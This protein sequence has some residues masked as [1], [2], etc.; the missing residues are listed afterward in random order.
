[1]NLIQLLTNENP[2]LVRIISIIFIVVQVNMFHRVF[3]KV[4]NI[5]TTRKKQLIF[6]AISSIFPILALWMPNSLLSDSLILLSFFLLLRHLFEQNIKN[7]LLAI[8]ITYFCVTLAESIVY[9]ICIFLLKLNSEEISNI[10]LYQFLIQLSGCIIFFFMPSVINW[11]KINI[12]KIYKNSK[13]HSKL[14]LASIFISGLITMILVTYLFSTTMGIIPI[15]LMLAIIASLLLYFSLTIYALARTDTLDKTKEDLANAQLYNQTLTILHDNI[16]GFKHDFNNIV[17]AIGGY[18]ALNDMDGLKSYYQRLL[19]ECKLTNNLN[20]LNPET[21]NN[22]SIYSLLTNKYFTATEKS[23][24]MNFSIF[25]DLSKLTSNTYE[26][27]RILGILLDNAI[28]AAEE[29]EKK[30]ISI[31]IKSDD[32][33]HVFVISNSCSNPNISTTKIF[34]KGYSTKNRDS[35]LGLWNVHKILSKNTNLD[36]YTTIEGDIF[37]QTFTIYHN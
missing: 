26:I 29:T 13:M 30:I 9:Y 31:E 19:V 24:T 33:K 36:L 35:G 20:L 22:P 27:S 2:I 10:P 25:S 3:T 37:S 34:E 21:I 28:E 12:Q 4:L 8:F 17:Q 14:T 15:H 5:P 7:S 1:M 18:V 11:V 6:I 16:R 23:I 32:K